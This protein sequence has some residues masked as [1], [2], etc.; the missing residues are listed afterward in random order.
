MSSYRVTATLQPAIGAPPTWLLHIEDRG[1]REPAR[2]NVATRYR[3]TVAPVEQLVADAIGASA[4]PVE[5]IETVFVLPAALDHE[6]SMAGSSPSGRSAALLR[7]RALRALA[8]AG[9]AEVDALLVLG[10]V[11][12]HG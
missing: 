6:V 11:A 2:R 8:R 10:A 7:N 9:V 4:P 5:H 1:A 12:A 3:P